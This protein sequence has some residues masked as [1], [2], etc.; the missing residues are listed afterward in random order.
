MHELSNVWW[1]SPAFKAGVT[2]DM[3]IVSV[4]G[5]AYSADVLRDAIL[6]AE[7]SKQPL[8]LQ[9]KRGDA[10]ESI[11]IPYFDGLRSPSLQ[12]VEGTPARLDDILAPSKA[13]LPTT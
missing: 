10:F 5:R 11:A 8:Q 9:F 6:A 3:D 4:N 7:K 1:G 12:R 2:P 13:P